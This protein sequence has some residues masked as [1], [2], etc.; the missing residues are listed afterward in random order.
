MLIV[1][2]LFFL[3]VWLVFLKFKWLPFNRTWKIVIWTMALAICLV[4]LG[5]LQYYTPVSKV[6][7]VEAPTQ[8]I[9]PVVSGYVDAV[10]VSASDSVSAGDK[11]FSID[12]RPFQYEVDNW[13]A[14]L[15]LAE[16]ALDDAK[17]LVTKGAIAQF[18]LDQ[19][20]AERDKARAELSTAQYNLENAVVVA[21]TDGIVSLVSLRPGQRVN[22]APVALSFIATNETWIAAAFKQNGLRL[23]APGQQVTVSFTSAPGSIY[24]T[25]V[26]AIPPGVVQGQITPEDAA[27]PLQALTSARNMY[28]VRIRMPAG[29]PSEMARPGTLAQATVFTDEGNPINV[30]AKILLWISAWADYVF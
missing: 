4:V 8:R 10:F 1:L 28:P 22:P 21:P 19:K 29:A 23:M 7:V 20:Q 5:A 25:K 15:K 3:V 24:Q 17:K 18:A 26:A 11:L 14:A 6:A 30:L 12:P 2:S 16:I 13:T 27:N 9:Y